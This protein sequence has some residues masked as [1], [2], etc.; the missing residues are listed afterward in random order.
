MTARK[1]WVNYQW[2]NGRKFVEWGDDGIDPEAG[3]S[4][5]YE[6]PE[7]RAANNPDLVTICEQCDMRAELNAANARY[8]IAHREKIHAA[9]AREADMVVSQLIVDLNRLP[10]LAADLALRTDGET[11]VDIANEILSQH[12]K[13]AKNEALRVHERRLIKKKNGVVND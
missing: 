2:R 12:K 3:S 11:L 5:F 13:S 10:Y 7:E 9:K 4:W 8:G 1:Y 6:T